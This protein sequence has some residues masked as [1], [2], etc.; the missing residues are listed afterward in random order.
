MKFEVRKLDDASFKVKI[1]QRLSSGYNYLVKTNFKD[2]VDAAGNIRDTI[3]TTKFTVYNAVNFTGLSG[4]IKGVVG[5][6]L[7][8]LEN[9]DNSLLRYTTPLNANGD[10]EF[11][12]VVPGKYKLW[13]FDDRKGNKEY[14]N[15][16]LIPYEH[17]ARFFVLPTI[18]ELIPRWVTF[19]FKWNVD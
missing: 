13:I 16:S 10:F 5:N 14:F 4:N 18:I 2:L 9:P 15:G 19:D 8:V 1:N 11:G 3:T 17:S 7:V 6:F 12:E